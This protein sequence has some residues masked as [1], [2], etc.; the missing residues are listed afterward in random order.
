MPQTNET[1][2]ATEIESKGVT[3]W[4]GTPA[5]FD[6]FSTQFISGGEGVQ[7]YGWGLYFA[8]EVEV[9]KW[10]RDVL[11]GHKS[12]L[13]VGEQHVPKITIEDIQ[14]TNQRYINYQ[15]AFFLEGMGYEGA[16]QRILNDIH[17]KENSFKFIPSIVE[18]NKKDVA[19]LTEVLGK[20][21]E[22]KDKTIRLDQGR[23]YQVKLEPHDDEYL[24]WD[25]PMTA[26]TDRVKDALALHNVAYSKSST[27]REFYENLVAEIESLDKMQ[28][29]FAART[30]ASQ[31]L[32]VGGYTA[33]EIASRYLNSIGIPGLKFLD[34]NS[35]S[36]GVGTYNYVVFD[37]VNVSVLSRYKRNPTYGGEHLN[38]LLSADDIKR[39]IEPIVSE[40]GVKAQIV[41]SFQEL[42]RHVLREMIR[43]YA[44]EDAPGV[45]DARTGQ[46]FLIQQNIKSPKEAV[47]SYLHEVKGHAAFRAALGEDYGLILD[48]IY[49]Q[50]PAGL[51]QSY[52]RENEAQLKHCTPTEKQ[53]VIAEEWVAGLAERNPK[54]TFVE[55]V[56]A[57]LRGWLRKI[58][59]DLSFS[60]SEIVAFLEKGTRVLN[61]KSSG[62][63]QGQKS[64]AKAFVSSRQEL[65]RALTRQGVELV[66]F[67]EGIQYHSHPK[68]KAEFSFTA[69]SQNS[70][71]V[72]ATVYSQNGSSVFVQVFG[73]E[74]KDVSE[75]IE[76][77]VTEWTRKNGLVVVPDPEQKPF[78]T[79][80]D[81][82][83]NSVADRIEGLHGR[84]DDWQAS[85]SGVGPSA[86][87]ARLR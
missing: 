13:W 27:G 17:H 9:A 25:K 46:A 48:K 72:D 76:S 11:A 84:S 32:D 3:A 57:V 1:N 7:A 74:S 80:N 4:H 20:V 28:W 29:H 52:Q 2:S 23:M 71:G 8:T 15:A 68:A 79:D 65:S 41:S 62:L 44:L 45:F 69:R 35:R 82:S 10:Y 43:D 38:T 34:Q 58:K 64:S 73:H 61:E 19:V 6:T 81:L 55:S 21:E 83:L 77:A 50:M 56:A 22:W 40:L 18:K 26:Q 36:N 63:E 51:K 16:K 60:S 87:K 30:L 59:P 85:N 86:P 5:E 78:S 42:P 67:G 14:E 66:Q 24:Q 54:N 70:T 39:A 75:K 47:Q 31:G 37:E 49:K 53:R 12:D 33:P